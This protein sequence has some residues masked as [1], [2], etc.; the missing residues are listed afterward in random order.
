VG[1]PMQVHEGCQNDIKL[2]LT[3]INLISIPAC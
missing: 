2:I 1:P 3:N